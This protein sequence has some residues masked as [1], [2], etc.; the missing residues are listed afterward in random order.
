M[1][2][3]ANQIV[4]SNLHNIH[5][6]PNIFVLTHTQQNI[7]WRKNWWSYKVHFSTLMVD[8]SDSSKIEEMPKWPITANSFWI[9]GHSNIS[10]WISVCSRAY[11]WKAGIFVLYINLRTWKQYAWHSNCATVSVALFWVKVDTALK[12]NCTRKIEV[13]YC[14]IIFWESKQRNIKSFLE[15]NEEKIK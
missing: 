13:Y 1:L 3:H 10:L 8:F 6:L 5:K 9:F 14:V 12:K 15:T 4:L 2:G 11:G 7:V